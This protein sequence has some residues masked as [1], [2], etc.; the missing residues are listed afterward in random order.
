M[1]TLL[2]PTQPRGR[3][4]SATVLLDELTGEDHASLQRMVNAARKTTDHRELADLFRSAVADSG[5]RARAETGMFLAMFRERDT[6]GAD[7]FFEA[8]KARA[9]GQE[10]DRIRQVADFQTARDRAAAQGQLGQATPAPT[11]PPAAKPAGSA[12]PRDDGRNPN[13]TQFRQNL[14]PWEGGFSNRGLKADPG[15]PTQKG[16]SEEFLK[17]L[18]KEHPGWGLPNDVR[19]LTDDQIDGIYRKEFFDKPNIQKVADM[20]GLPGQ[21]PKLAEQLFDTGVL[22]GT[23]KAGKFL[24]QSLDQVLGTD[25]RVTDAQGRKAHDGIVGS[26]TRAA[27]AQAVRDGKAAKVNDA[28]VSKRLAFMRTLPNFASNPAWVR[29]E[30]SFKTGTP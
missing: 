19:K 17:L 25:L 13:F 12:G 15:G 22:H 28:M 7:R 6:E 20:P 26:G 10:A 16:I 8:F 29:R 24:Q 18:N 9:G 3:R 2:N 23:S 11:Q 27:I 4:R 30:E 1:T 14:K 5:E 21:A